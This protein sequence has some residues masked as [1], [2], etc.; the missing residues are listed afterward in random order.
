MFNQL[1]CISRPINQW[2]AIK[3]M[4][5][6]LL[7]TPSLVILFISALILLPWLIPRLRRKRILSTFGTIILVIYLS[8]TLP[9]TVAIANKGLVSF[10]PPDPGNKVDAIVILGRGEQ[11]RHSRVKVAARLWEMGRAPL[12]F[13]SGV[14]DG[15]EI[16]EQLKEEGIPDKVLAE[17]HCSRTTKENAL[18]TA[19]ILQ[20]QGIKQIL[21][22]TDP[23][24]M[25]RSILTFKSAGFEVIPHSSPVPS[26]LVQSRKAMLIFY[27]YMGLVSYGL[28]GHFLPSDVSQQD[29]QQF[30]SIQSKDN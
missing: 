21:L 20:N 19:S 16:V 11:L 7:M 12:I 1:L 18:F 4:M 29:N 24:H 23:P 28:H 3:S 14:G 13:A 8:A 10:I 2:L 17:E 25:L 9:F 30:A 26:A 5:A 6:K 27:E 22:V 15:K